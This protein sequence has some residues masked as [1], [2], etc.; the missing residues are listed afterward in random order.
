MTALCFLALPAGVAGASE[1]DTIIQARNA[2]YS[3]AAHGFAN[4]RCNLTPNWMEILRDGFRTNPA[5]AN[6]ALDILK[7]LIFVVTVANGAEAKVTHNTVA[8][9]NKIMAEGL[10]QIYSGMEQTVVGF[11]TTWTV[12][13]V[14]PPLPA[15]DSDYRLQDQG[16]RWH[17]SYKERAADIATIMEKDFSVREMAVSSAEFGSMLQPKFAHTNEGLLLTSYHANYQGKTAASHDKTLLD[18]LIGYQKINGLQVP[19]KLNIG[20]SYN[21]SPFKMEVLFSNCTATKH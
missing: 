20:G 7:K 3:L 6:H 1:K 16:G 10:Q 19:K 9:E 4:F 8:A 13:V 21:D 12:F 17:L 11:F 14:N 18:V 15:P 5:G 2:Y